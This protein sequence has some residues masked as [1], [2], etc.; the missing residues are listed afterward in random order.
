MQDLSVDLKQIR[1]A[2]DFL[3]LQPPQFPKFHVSA[4][5][6]VQGTRLLLVLNCLQ[7]FVQ[8]SRPTCANLSLVSSLSLM[9]LMSVM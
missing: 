8:L 1:Q 2:A 7:Y 4:V 3:F 5:G 9:R 6:I